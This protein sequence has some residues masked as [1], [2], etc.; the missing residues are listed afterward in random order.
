M[1]IDWDAEQ[2]KCNF[3]LTDEQFSGFEVVFSKDYSEPYETSYFG[4]LRKNGKLY[5]VS[6]GTCSCYGCE[7]QFNPIETSLEDLKTDIDYGLTHEEW[8]S[9]Y[10]FLL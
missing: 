9:I 10:D 1:R 7:G 3:E 8:S 6:C 2:I 5:K 4:V